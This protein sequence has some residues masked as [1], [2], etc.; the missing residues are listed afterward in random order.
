[1]QLRYNLDNIFES[2]LYAILYELNKKMLVKEDIPEQIS[3]RLFN[4]ISNQIISVKRPLGVILASK[5]EQKAKFIST[6]DD[7]K[8][9]LR[10]RF[11]IYE[12][13]RLTSESFKKKVQ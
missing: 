7:Y 11:M 4:L 10:D 13:N 9:G 8:Q 1:V 12:L 5:I 3:N 2:D 6:I